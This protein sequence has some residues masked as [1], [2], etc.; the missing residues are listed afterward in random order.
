VKP[1]NLSQILYIGLYNINVLLFYHN[2]YTYITGRAE[3]GDDRQMISIRII[4]GEESSPPGISTHPL[5]L[6]NCEFLIFCVSENI[7]GQNFLPTVEFVSPPPPLLVLDC[8]DRWLCA[9]HSILR[10]SHSSY[11]KEFWSHPT[12]TSREI[13]WGRWQIVGSANVKYDVKS[14]RPVRYMLIL[15]QPITCKAVKITYHQ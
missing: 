12:P 11:Q 9:A 4:K 6:Q 13:F 15:E 5:K 2:K 7:S 1:S 10:T 3:L 14:I 8:H